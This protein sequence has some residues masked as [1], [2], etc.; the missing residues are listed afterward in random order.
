MHPAAMKPYTTNAGDAADHSASEEGGIR[1]DGCSCSVTSSQESGGGRDAG[2]GKREVLLTPLELPGVEQPAGEEAALGS[3][4][5]LHHGVEDLL[6]ALALGYA[7]RGTRSVLA[8]LSLDIL[9]RVLRDQV[10]QSYW[11]TRSQLGLVTPLPRSP[12]EIADNPGALVWNA[13]PR[14]LRRTRVRGEAGDGL[15]GV[16]GS[17]CICCWCRLGHKKCC[18]Q[19]GI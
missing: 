19:P 9:Q 16:E 1:A 8:Q 12:M 17:T 15:G 5:F 13:P 3:S 6:L 18:G 10:E 7:L 4:C 14:V 2:G 11:A